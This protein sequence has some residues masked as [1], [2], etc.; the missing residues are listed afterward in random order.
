[1]QPFTIGDEVVVK[2]NGEENYQDEAEI[3]TTSGKELCVRVT[4]SDDCPACVG[5]IFEFGLVND[6]WQ[7]LDEGTYSQNSPGYTISKK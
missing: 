5:G 2:R 6:V 1:M 3:V 4:K 7:L